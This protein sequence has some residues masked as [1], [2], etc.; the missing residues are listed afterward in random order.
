MTD[1]LM[2]GFKCSTHV[3]GDGIRLD[4]IAGRSHGVHALTDYRQCAAQGIV[5]FRDGL[6]W[7][8][9]EPARGQYD[10]SSWAPMVE[11][12]A[13][14]GAQVYWDLFRYGFP[15]WADPLSDDFQ[16]IFADYAP[17]AAQEHV[18]LTDRQFDFCAMN[19]ISYLCWAA[20]TDHFTVTGY[21]PGNRLKAA[22]VGAAITACRAIAE[23]GIGGAYLGRTAGPGG[24]P[25][26]RR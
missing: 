21:Q 16:A 5:R 15:D 10:W 22:L 9:I 14:A 25:R 19:E 11:A 7:H 18:R 13:S 23:A 20:K 26:V 12:A 3:R 8:R 17:T 2:A 1:L 24:A 6:R 4:L